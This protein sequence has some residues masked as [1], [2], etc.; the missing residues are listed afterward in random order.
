[1]ALKKGDRL[2]PNGRPKGSENKLN[3]DLRSKL[4]TIIE[5][6]I[7]N[8]QSDLDKLKPIERLQVI[9][10]LLSFVLPKLQAQT[11]ELDMNSLSDA[12]VDE[13]INSIQIDEKLVTIKIVDE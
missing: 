7:D 4:K 11:I 2:N 5:N 6:N 10:R 8:V 9:E 13:I 12:Q 3:A 1:M